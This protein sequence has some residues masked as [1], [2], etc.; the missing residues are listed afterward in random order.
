MPKLGSSVY[1]ALI[2]SSINQTV[3]EPS[4]YFRF[5]QEFDIRTLGFDTLV[6]SNADTLNAELDGK[7]LSVRSLA[8]DIRFSH[9]PFPPFALDFSSVSA[10]AI[11]L[12]IVAMK[13]A[14]EVAS[15]VF[16]RKLQFVASAD[17]SQLDPDGDDGTRIVFAVVDSYLNLQPDTNASVHINVTGPALLVG[18]SDF[19]V[20]S[21]AFFLRPLGI[22]GLATVTILHSMFPAVTVNVRIGNPLSVAD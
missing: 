14:I 16:D 21:G 7:F 2:A 4:F 11:S 5:D 6:W 18:D 22:S 13:G 10:S 17:S 12:R 15:R 8:K 20:S 3:I 9:L 1:R 19:G